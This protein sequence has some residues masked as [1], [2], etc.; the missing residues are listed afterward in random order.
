MLGSLGLV[1]L[2]GPFITLPVAAIGD[3]ALMA[4]GSDP[5][6]LRLFCYS[7]RCGDEEWRRAASPLDD[8]L[9]FDTT[10]RARRVSPAP[11]RRS[12]R[13]SCGDSSSRTRQVTRWVDTADPTAPVRRVQVDT[14][15]ATFPEAR[16]ARRGRL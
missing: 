14:S 5:A 8:H 16:S 11:S 13:C 2:T 3:P 12:Q 4:L 15:G 7:I 9:V 1:L 6:Q 10:G